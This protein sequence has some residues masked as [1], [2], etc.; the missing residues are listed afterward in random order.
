MRG[1]I[2]HQAILP[3]TRP[4]IIAAIDAMVPRRTTHRMDYE[5]R[6][7]PLQVGAQGIEIAPAVRTLIK[8]QST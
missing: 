2:H 7:M 1:Q 4:A 3:A 5:Q 8:D 6:Q